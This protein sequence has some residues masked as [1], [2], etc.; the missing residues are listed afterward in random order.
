MMAKYNVAEEMF[1]NLKDQE[2]IKALAKKCC[3]CRDCGKDCPCEDC[4][5]S[6]KGCHEMEKKKDAMSEIFSAMSKI[7]ELQEEFGFLESSFITTVAMETMAEEISKVSWEDSNE[8]MDWRD[9]S[10]NPDFMTR[11]RA[12]RAEDPEA[13]RHIQHRF[14]ESTLSPE[15]LKEHY[16]RHGGQHLLSKKPSV[17]NLF[18]PKE[19]IEAV[20]LEKDLIDRP[21]PQQTPVANLYD[22]LNP[23]RPEWLNE[24]P[25]VPQ[26]DETARPARPK[27]N[28]YD[29]PTAI[30][31]YSEEELKHS[32]VATAKK[33]N[34]KKM[35]KSFGPP[36]EWSGSVAAAAGEEGR[37][38]MQEAWGGMDKEEKAAVK[39]KW[40]K[41][42]KKA[43]GLMERIMKAAH[44]HEVCDECGE[45]YSPDENKKR[46]EERDEIPVEDRLA[47]DD[48]VRKL[49]HIHEPKYRD[50]E[51]MEDHLERSDIDP[52]D[53]G[54]GPLRQHE[55]PDEYE[56]NKEVDP[57]NTDPFKGKYISPFNKEN[58]EEHYELLKGDENAAEDGGFDAFDLSVAKR[59]MIDVMTNPQ[60][61]VDW[62]AAE[63]AKVIASIMNLPN[64][65][66]ELMAL[67]DILLEK[68]EPL[69]FEEETE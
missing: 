47:W 57:V 30:Y 67:A 21:F 58:D 13:M 24:K 29:E 46:I 22:L 38:A 31:P 15:A 69:D 33:L 44:L 49:H 51:D 52:E 11:M 35:L 3:S 50:F 65:P 16:K 19:S 10:K 53:L 34:G 68:N 55:L 6:C 9:L 40:Q 42:M 36:N 62:T 14:N 63:L 66:D 32:K 28:F 56:F 1:K 4:G 12:E 5:N 64:I 2:S 39:E 54:A 18:E 61:N 26:G 17:H 7:A 43:D 45:E 41:K 59:R 20:P 25:E 23:S 8:V 48:E 60:Y 37:K 27:A